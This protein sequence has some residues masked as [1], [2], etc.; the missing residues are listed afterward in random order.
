MPQIAYA[1]AVW[2]IQSLEETLLEQDLADPAVLKPLLRP[3]LSLSP[4]NFVGL[5]LG[6][7]LGMASLPSLLSRHFMTPTVRDARW[8]AVF[9]LLFATLLVTAAPALAAYAKLSLLSLIGDR[10]ALASLPA[11]MFTYGNLGLVE[12]CGRA[13]TDAAAVA[14]ACAELPDAHDGRCACRTSRSIP[15]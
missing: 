10:V 12:I 6:L 13:A 14:K 5:V 1:N 2:Q 3:F 11:W 4:L 15:T 8:S 9:A 7:A